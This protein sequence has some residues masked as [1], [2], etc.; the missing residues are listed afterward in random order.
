MRSQLKSDYDD[1]KVYREGLCLYAKGNPNHV[2]MAVS[3]A[4]D[5]VVRRGMFGIGWK[6]NGHKERVEHSG[7]FACLRL[8]YCGI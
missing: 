1:V 4:F 2:R 8:R 3:L 5:R 7:D 6:E